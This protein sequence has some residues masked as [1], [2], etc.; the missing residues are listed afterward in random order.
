MNYDEIEEKLKQI[1]IED[2]IWIIYIGIIILSWY[3]NSLERK[4][5]ISDSEEFRSKYQSVMIFIFLVLLIIY[6]YFL[7][8]SYNEYIKLDSCDTD[9]KKELITLALI[10]TL[11]LTISGTIFLYIAIEDKNIDVELAFN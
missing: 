7:K 6:L 10:A 11:L 4:Y 9:K 5:I 2:Y 1:K 8:G 3:A